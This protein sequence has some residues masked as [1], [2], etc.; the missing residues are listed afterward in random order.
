MSPPRTKVRK[1]SSLLAIRKTTGINSSGFSYT[2]VRLPGLEPRI[3]VPKTAVISISPQ[4][5]Y[6]GICKNLFLHMFRMSACMIL[7]TGAQRSYACVL[8]QRSANT[9]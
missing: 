4:A 8:K 3:T 9:I 5:R 6:E 2:L 7:H 1:Q